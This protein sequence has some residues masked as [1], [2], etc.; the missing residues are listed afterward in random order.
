M[1]L[2]NY[3]LKLVITACVIF[4]TGTAGFAQN[5]KWQKMPLLVCLPPNPNNAMMKQAFTDWQKAAKDKVTFV[6]LTANSCTDA[7]IT[8]SYAPQKMK[9][10]TNFSYRQNYFTKAHIEMGLLT[11]E[12]NKANNALLLPLMKHEVGHA[13]GIIG[14]SN[15]P[16]SV[17]QAT[18]KEGYKITPDSIMEIYRIYK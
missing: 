13:I 18:V 12:G 15:T 11:R 8:V 1:M 2:K 9:S 5:L 10:L 17:M 4:I 6:F 14:H 16:Q 7:Q 3:I